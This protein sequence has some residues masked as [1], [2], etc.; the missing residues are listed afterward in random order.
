MYPQAKQANKTK[1][2]AT[3]NHAVGIL[4]VDAVVV[5]YLD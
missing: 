1:I 5:S 4:G 3:I 2:P